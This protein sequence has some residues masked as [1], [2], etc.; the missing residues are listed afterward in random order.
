M[1]RGK[2][3]PC[4][5]LAGLTDL[6]DGSSGRMPEARSDEAE[7]AESS[8]GAQIEPSSRRTKGAVARVWA[9]GKSAT[10]CRRPAGRTDFAFKDGSSGKMP[11]ARWGV[12][13][14]CKDGSSGRMPEARF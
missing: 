3:L 14:V 1:R 4:V 11:E 8:F 12:D 6:E 9:W 2:V 13:R 7:R 5:S 10:C